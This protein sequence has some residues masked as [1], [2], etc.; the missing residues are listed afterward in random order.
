[1]IKIYTDG[2]SRGN[3][4]PGGWGSIIA[5]GNVGE[6]VVV[7]IGGEEAHT[8][9]NRMELTA[10]IKA[11][12]FAS[13]NF[14]PDSPMEI[15]TDSEYV[16]KGITLWIH[17]WQKKGWKTSGKKAVL[18]KDLWQ[19]LLIVTEEKEIT[20]KHVTG[21]SGHGLNER[22]DEIATSFADGLEVIL[23]NGDK[24]SYQFL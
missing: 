3:P 20:W 12:E 4:G 18:N 19:E 17:S 5:G 6:E 21:H 16:M 14:P 22:C 23:Y 1:M 10:A 11:V 13:E 9:N 7:E 24:S 15:Y 2:S 8:T